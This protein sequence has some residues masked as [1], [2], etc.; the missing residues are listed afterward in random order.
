MAKADLTAQ[1]LRELLQYDPETGVFTRL[2]SRQG[3]RAQAGDVAGCKTAE[4]YI[5]ISVDQRIYPAH[6]LAWLFMHGVLPTGDIDH[7]DGDKANNRIENLRDVSTSVNMQNQRRAQPRNAS[8]YLGVTR[9]GNRFEASIKLNGVNRY[10]GSYATPE[11]AHA[12][13][14]AEKRRIH[15]GC[16]I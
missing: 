11:E 8:G 5:R 1:R 13:Y 7:I 16:T 14:M 10:I 12:S 3:Y 2:I 9:H 15:P 6:R 4:G